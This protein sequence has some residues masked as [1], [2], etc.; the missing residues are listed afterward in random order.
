MLAFSLGW[1]ALD[2][3]KEEHTGRLDSGSEGPEGKRVWLIQRLFEA[4][5][6]FVSVHI[7]FLNL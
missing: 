2:G 1:I 7:A 3:V 4:L 5:A 6:P